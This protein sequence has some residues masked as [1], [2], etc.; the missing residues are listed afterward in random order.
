MTIEN[1]VAKPTAEATAI[2]TLAKPARTLWGGTNA[3]RGAGKTYLPKESAESEEAYDSRL[4]RTVLF[5]AFAKTVKDMA[6]RVFA[7]ELVLADDVPPQIVQ[8]CEN[9]DLTGRHISVFARDVFQ[10]ALQAGVSYILV[11]SPPAVEGQTLADAQ[12]QG[13]R[14]YLVHI[15]AEQVL[16]WRS[17]LSGGAERLTQFRFSESITEPDGEYGTRTVEQIRVFLPSAYEVWRKNDKGEWVLY[18]NGVRG[19]DDIPIYAVALDRTGFMSGKPPLQDLIDLNITHWQS[20]SDQRNILHVARVPILFGAGFPDE[21]QIVIGTSAMTRASDAAAT[22]QYVEHSGAAI[23]SGREDLKD[24]EFQMQTMGLQLLTPQPGQTATGEVRD[25]IKE[26]SQLAAMANAMKD[27]LENALVAMAQLGG[28]GSDG[29]S[30]EVNTDY[31]ITARGM[32]DLQTLLSAVQAG[33]ISRKTFWGELLR[34][35]VL[36][37]SFDPE[38]ELELIGDEALALMGQGDAPVA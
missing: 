4:K 7:K 10:D 25:D 32:Q 35:G 23:G 11:D 3:M 30:I 8:W 9:V 6:G 18:D 22:L 15:K 26:T 20:S 2:Q 12:A 31:G 24:L 27:A 37:D 29:G 34:R 38:M 13:T 28:L 14:P 5:N 17:E 1:P 19:I 21:A 16:G 33:L 36:A